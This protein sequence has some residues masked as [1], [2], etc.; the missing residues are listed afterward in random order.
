MKSKINFA[1]Q[2]IFI[3]LLLCQISKQEIINHQTFYL[4]SS[5]NISINVDLFLPF[6]LL[7]NELNISHSKGLKLQIPK[8]Y[9]KT[10]IYDKINEPLIDNF[11]A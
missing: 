9:Q 5:D 3:L 11:I 8:S 4:N 7:L 2:S 1:L 10:S 6:D